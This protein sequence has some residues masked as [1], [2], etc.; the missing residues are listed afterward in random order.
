MAIV[1]Q[2]GFAGYG[3]FN[4]IDKADK[5]GT[6]TKKTIENGFDPHGVIGA[7]IIVVMLLLAISAAAGRVGSLYV[8]WA[9]G[10]LVLGLLQM[11]FAYL[12]TKSAAVGGFLHGI[13]ALA[14]YAGAAVLA[15]RAWTQR[16]ADTVAP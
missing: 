7:V 3:A 9:V 4:A 13:N 10:L 2:V 1:V 14:I 12:G 8:K 11:L 5:D 6:I 16:P 15:H